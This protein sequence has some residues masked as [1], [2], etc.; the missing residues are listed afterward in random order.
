MKDNLGFS[1]VEITV[2]VAI[3]SSLAVSISYYIDDKLDD[4]KKQDSLSC[5]MDA[6][7]DSYISVADMAI[8]SQCYL[9]TPLSH[10]QVW[11]EKNCQH[12]DFDDNNVVNALD[13]AQIR[14]AVSTVGSPTARKRCMVNVKEH[15]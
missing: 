1:L 15:I 6:N 13:Y 5:R 10:P 9:R 8:F 3:V 14:R 7:R 11:E 4:M 12:F 2:S